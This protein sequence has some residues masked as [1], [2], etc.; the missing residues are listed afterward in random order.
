MPFPYY[1]NLSVSKKRIYRKSDAI[2]RIPVKSSGRIH[3]VT[4]RLKES[5]AE[6]KRREVAKHA[7]DI[8]RLVCEG[9]G[10]EA[11]IVRIRS[12]RPSRST[13]ELQGLY[14]RMEG[15][16]CVLTVWMKTAAKGR[17]VAF[18][19][20]I[21]TVLHELCHHL[22]YVHFGLIDSLHTG[23]FFK[24]ESDLY[25]QIVP[26]ELQKREPGKKKSSRK[27]IKR[28]RPKEPEQMRLI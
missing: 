26:A 25:R 8:C 9:L 18:K 16:T 13:E 11:L 2:E 19:S 3:P 12:G 17:V 28:Q 23:G 15:E 4:I 24:R 6:N 5:L 1:D 21:R 22:D 7:S 14:E 27:K 20:F 10:A